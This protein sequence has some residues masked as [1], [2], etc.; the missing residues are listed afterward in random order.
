MDLFI[1]GRGLRTCGQPRNKRIKRV[2]YILNNAQNMYVLKTPTATEHTSEYKS[3]Y[4]VSTC[5]LSVA[6]FWR[7]F[8][9][10]AFVYGLA[11]AR[12][13]RIIFP[14]LDRHV[15]AIFAGDRKNPSYLSYLLARVAD[16]RENGCSHKCA[17][18]LGAS[19]RLIY[20]Y[21]KFVVDDHR[22]CANCGTLYPCV[23]WSIQC[24]PSIQN[25]RL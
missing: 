25:S 2:Q 6:V 5:L 8:L 23:C 10:C 9:W 18:S 21:I 20:V 16:G 12:I 7:C 3:S 11:N 22:V 24:K 19:L 4:F 13:L 1:V 14:P 15:L 17:E